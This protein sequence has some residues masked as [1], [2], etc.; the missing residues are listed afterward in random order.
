MQIFWKKKVSFRE[1]GS[2]G[3]VGK[4]EGRDEEPPRTQIE[5]RRF[6]VTPWIVG[7]T[8]VQATAIGL[9]VKTDGATHTDQEGRRRC[10]THIMRLS[11]ECKVV[12]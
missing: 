4:G 10:V 7:P 5:K 3:G 6:V 9:E 2:E 1:L 11:R 12:S 8:S